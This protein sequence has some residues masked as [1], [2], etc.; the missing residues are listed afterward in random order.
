MRIHTILLLL[1]IFCINLLGVSQTDAPLKIKINWIDFLDENFSFKE[2]WSYPEGV[3]MNS[4]GQLSCDGICPPEIDRMKDDQ[5]KIYPDSLQAF[6]KIVDTTHLSH[7]IKSVAWTYEW[8]GTDFINFERQSNNAI[9]G[10][11]E[12]TV[13][14]HSSLHIKINNDSLTAWIDFNSIRDLGKH[15]FP[16]KKGQFKMERSHFN[17]GII[18]AVFDLKFENTINPAKEIYW[19]GVIYSEIKK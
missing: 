11:T 3:Y 6:Y 18:K 10:Q 15:I 16:M 4:F 7:S 13:S 17:K 9:I 2:K 14:T 19:K 8:A 5:G 12:C 1:F